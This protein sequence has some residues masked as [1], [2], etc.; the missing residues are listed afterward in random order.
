MERQVQHMVRL[1]DDLLDVSRITR[2]KI[3]L[4]KEA[5]EITSLVQRSVEAIEPQAKTNGLSLRLSLPTEP[6]VVTADST[7]LDQVMINLLNNALK[8]TPSGGVIE[9]HVVLQGRD[10][11]ISVRDTGVGIEPELLPEIFE[12]F[13][14]GSRTLDR[15]QGGLGI[16]LTL[17][18]TL[19]EMHSGTV[20]AQSAGTGQGSEFVVVLPLANS[21]REAG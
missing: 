2:G 4:R 12:P 6:V 21:L 14:Q 15:S 20:T 10:L 19:V 18:R 9:V 5:I 11:L 3:E 1:V 8:F 7:R 13:P 16:G 17:V